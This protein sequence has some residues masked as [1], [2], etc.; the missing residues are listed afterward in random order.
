M[1]EVG[2]EVLA[3]YESINSKRFEGIIFDI[4]ED[5]LDPRNCY[6]HINDGS[7]KY[8]GRFYGYELE[9]K[10]PFRKWVN[11]THAVN[12]DI[13]LTPDNK[14]NWLHMVI[15]PANPYDQVLERAQYWEYIRHWMN[16]SREA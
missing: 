2:D 1:L 8:V 9:L 12:L 13:E 14:Q 11:Q 5:P 6:Y 3:H 15:Y 7:G 16:W 4:E 10:Y